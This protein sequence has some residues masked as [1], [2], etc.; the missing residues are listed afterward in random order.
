[1]GRMREAN[2]VPRRLDG[3]RGRLIGN[4]VSPTIA[5]WIARKVIEIEEI[6]ATASPVVSK[7]DA[8][9]ALRLQNV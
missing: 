5:E 3:R 8:T 1:M 9:Q 2:G 4:S 7:G 6:Y